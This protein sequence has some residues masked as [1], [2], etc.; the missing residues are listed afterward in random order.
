MAA[1]ETDLLSE[2]VEVRKEV[3]RDLGRFSDETE[4]PRR[5][6]LLIQALSDEN[7]EVRRQA[8]LSLADLRASEAVSAILTML[9]DVEIRVR[10]IAVLALGEVAAPSDSEVLGRLA[11]LLRA[12]DASIRYQAL[13]AR[14]QL[15][16]EDIA[17]DIAQGLSDTD[18]EIREL[19]IRLGDEVLLENDR[20]IS[21]ELQELIV[22]ACQDREN[23]V[24]IVAQLLAAS[25]GW[26]A[27][28]D[29]I[30][31]I[32]AGRVR[33][34]EPRDEQ[35]AIRLC[36]ILRLESAIPSLE[37]R[38]YGLLGMSLDPF[39]W[40]ALGSLARLGEPRAIARLG[41][42]LEIKE[43]DGAGICGRGIG[44]FRAAGGILAIVSV[45]RPESGSGSRN[46]GEGAQKPW[47]VAAG[48][49]G[50]HSESC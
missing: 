34:R 4:R 39:R 21:K 24:R 17:L 6:T 50:K 23:R 12:G 37:R 33:V 30:L 22:G 8:L 26:E 38:A 16:P 43:F 2:D 45:A 1:C 47:A 42:S 40:V 15:A 46:L 29:M 20:E 41:K 3:T 35:E 25:Q 44:A 13:L 32:A 11:S 14:S 10:Q 36:G 49:S 7:S 27:S 19:A 9:S 28:R 5:V 31:K 48:C 18:P